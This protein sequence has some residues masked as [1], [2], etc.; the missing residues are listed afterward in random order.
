[1]RFA[2]L[3]FLVVACA[4]PPPAPAVAVPQGRVPSAGPAFEDT[5]DDA[6]IARAGEAYLALVTSIHPEQA[7]QLGIHSADAELDDRS[8]EGEERAVGREE[9]MAGDLASKFPKGKLHASRSA[10]TDL[11]VLRHLL[12]VDVRVHREMRPLERQ[13]DVYTEPMNA[14]FL[15]VARD[16]A[17]AADRARAVLQRM[18]K[19]PAV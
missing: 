18:R 11:V 3:L 1:M 16:Y 6:A 5:S 10:R 14:V 8:L 19:I 15:M 4:A 17:P 9:A 7:T 12:E 2:P 13:P